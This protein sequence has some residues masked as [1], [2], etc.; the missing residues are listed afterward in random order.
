MDVCAVDT[1]KTTL[2]RS[3]RRGMKLGEGLFEGCPIQLRLLSQVAEEHCQLGLD[4]LA[5]A[6]EHDGDR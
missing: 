2:S 1:L 4:F 5:Q 6:G 3:A